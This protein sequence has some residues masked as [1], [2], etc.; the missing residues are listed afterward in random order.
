MVLPEPTD[1]YK[2]PISAQCHGYQYVTL[3]EN[4]AAR[5]V[6]TIKLRI[7]NVNNDAHFALSP[8]KDHN[9]DFQSEDIAW[10]LVLGGW[11]ATKTCIRWHI[12]QDCLVEGTVFISATVVVIGRYDYFGL[13]FN[14]SIILC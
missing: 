4:M 8:V 5:H 2:L 3:L 1:E 11:G 12:Q 6:K 9:G 7:D 10:E 13:V 14:L